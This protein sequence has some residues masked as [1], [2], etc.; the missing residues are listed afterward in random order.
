VAGL[1]NYIAAAAA[2][3]A[4]GAALGHEGFPAKG[5]TP[6]AAIAGARVD[7][8]LIDKHGVLF[9]RAIKKARRKTSPKIELRTG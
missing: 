4:A 3:A 1:E 2:I 5:D 8:Y 9:T 7:F 6:A